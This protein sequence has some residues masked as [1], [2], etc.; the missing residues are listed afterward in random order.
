MKKFL[1]TLA[2]AGVAVTALASCGGKEEI[3]IWVSES[4]GVVE[5]TLPRVKE[6]LESQGK[7]PDDYK[8]TVAGVGE[9]DA[10]SNVLSAFD[11][12]ADIYCF[13]Q[14]QLARLVQKNAIIQV[15]QN[16][17]ADVKSR[18]D[19]LSIK[20][21]TVGDK[22]YAYPLTSDNGYC[23]FYNKKTMEGVDMTKLEDIIAKCESSKTN[24]AWN[25][26]NVWFSAGFFFGT[27]CESSW[28]T[29]EKGEFTA[30]KDT[31]NS[32]NGLIA[33]KGMYKLLSSK[34]WIDKGAAS[35]FDSATKASVVITGS[36]DSKTAQKALGDDYAVTKLPTFTVGEKSYQIGSFSGCK[37]MGVKPQKDASRVELLTG[38]ANYLSGEECGKERLEKFGWGSANKKVQETDLFKNDLCL[39]ALA[40]QAPYS[41][42]QGNILGDWWG[43]GNNIA[44][45]AK[46]TDG[47]DAKLKEILV[48]YEDKLGKAFKGEEYDKSAVGVYDKITDEDKD[49]PAF[50]GNYTNPE[51]KNEMKSCVMTQDGHNWTITV[52]VKKDNLARVLKAGTWDTLANQTNVKTGADLV[53]VNADDGDKNLKFLADGKYKIT[54]NDETKDI[55]VEKLA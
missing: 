15:N 2:V 11:S 42:P 37:L 50:V 40:A 46:V 7:K 53:S 47:S 16:H 49:K 33:M 5:A 32:D 48:R 28:T 45:E 55:T 27:G 1:S 13:A 17:V 30:M 4:E 14:D 31:F 24:F 35:E 18:N 41:I 9:G 12:A 25:L 52:E 6:Y 39:K 10:A 36:W 34:N 3:K 44:L 26:G 23:M 22:L 19:E 54:Y 21:A 51:W 29:N 8:I 38:L 43:L 20:C